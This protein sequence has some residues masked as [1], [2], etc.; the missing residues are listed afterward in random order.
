MTQHHV[1]TQASLFRPHRT[2]LQKP[3]LEKEE[4]LP[5]NATLQT[6]SNCGPQQA[7]ALEGTS[8]QTLAF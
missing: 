7:P 4:V 5:E 2:T 1:P 6:L 8:H 3:A